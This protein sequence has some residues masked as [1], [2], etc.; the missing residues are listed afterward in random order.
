MNFYWSYLN[1][2]NITIDYTFEKIKDKITDIIGPLFKLQG[3]I[4]NANSEKD[5]SAP[6]IQMDT[7]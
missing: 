5:G 1:K 3:M 2:L 6:M 7:V 4:E